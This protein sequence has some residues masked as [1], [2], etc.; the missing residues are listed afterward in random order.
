M[1]HTWHPPEGSHK[2]NKKKLATKKYVDSKTKKLLISFSITC[3]HTKKEKIP[4]LP[5]KNFKL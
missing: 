4:S 3:S 2:N 5:M 1:V